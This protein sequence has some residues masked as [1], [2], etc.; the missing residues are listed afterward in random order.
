MLLSDI[1]LRHKSRAIV[2]PFFAFAANTIVEAGRLDLFR[3]RLSAIESCR[4]TGIAVAQIFSVASRKFRSLADS[5]V[6][7]PQNRLQSRGTSRA[8]GGVSK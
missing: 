1:E 6:Y 5:A 8:L 4:D 2:R 7:P 3:F